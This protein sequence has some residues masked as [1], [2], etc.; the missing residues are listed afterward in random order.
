M[1]WYARDVQLLP[2]RKREDF[3]PFWYQPP[4]RDLNTKWR[5]T[6][7]SLK[8]LNYRNATDRVSV[9]KATDKLHAMP[10]SG[11]KIILFF[12]LDHYRVCY[13]KKYFLVQAEKYLTWDFVRCTSLWP[14]A[15]RF[16]R[17]RDISTKCCHE[18]REVLIWLRERNC[19]S[20]LRICT[21]WILSLYFF[22]GDQWAAQRKTFWYCN[23]LSIFSDAF[24]L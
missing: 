16:W 15:H 24:R 20:T 7:S 14:Q 9:I 10:N 1:K 23:F 5:T 4:F 12:A 21:R 6:Y 13:L 18:F 19:S 3:I 22:N 2:N 8:R 11:K 17:E